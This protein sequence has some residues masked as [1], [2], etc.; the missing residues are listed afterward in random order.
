MARPALRTS[1]LLAWIM[2]LLTL[3]LVLAD[4]LIT[5]ISPSDRRDPRTDRTSAEAADPSCPPVSRAVAPNQLIK[6]SL[7]S[8]ARNLPHFDS[9]LVSNRPVPPGSHLLQVSCFTGPSISGRGAVR[10][11]PA[12]PRAA[13]S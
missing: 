10:G 7:A 1:N 4:A 5:A 2:L 12:L 8:E 3:L 9:S 13:R 6:S 11:F